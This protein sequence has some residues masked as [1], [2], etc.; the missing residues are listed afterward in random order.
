MRFANL[1]L[2]TAVMASMIVAASACQ[3]A[4]K[5]A[6]LLPPPSAPALKPASAQAST[7]PVAT[8]P[9]KEETPQQS[10][11]PEASTPAAATSASDP[12]ADLIAKVEKEYQAGLANHQAG[13]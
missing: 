1:Y 6:T 11:S 5:P 10:A 13:K 4:Q 8:I 12:V 7:A 3:T 2:P 9:Q